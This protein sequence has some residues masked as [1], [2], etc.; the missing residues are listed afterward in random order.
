MD[1]VP[2]EADVQGTASNHVSSEEPEEL[3]AVG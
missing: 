1:G 2:V 3:T